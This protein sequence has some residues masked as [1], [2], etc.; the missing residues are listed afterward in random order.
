MH[1]LHHQTTTRAEA[2]RRACLADGLQAHIMV[3]RVPLRGLF[4]NIMQRCI[5]QGLL[6]VS[7]VH[8]VALQ[9]PPHRPRHPAV[10]WQ[11]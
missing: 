10:A 11:T 2:Q 1:V 6:Q 3:A 8:G 7:K 4:A 5:V 9:P